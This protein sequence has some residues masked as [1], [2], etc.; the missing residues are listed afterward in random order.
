MAHREQLAAYAS[1]VWASCSVSRLVWV[2][3]AEQ[4]QQQQP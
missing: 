2:N 3:F 4:L 1:W